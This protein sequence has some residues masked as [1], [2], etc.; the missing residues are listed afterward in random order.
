MSVSISDIYSEFHGVAPPRLGVAGS[1]DLDDINVLI[2]KNWDS[3][4]FSDFDDNPWIFVSLPRLAVPYYLGAY[5]VKSM[6][7]D[8]FM[9][10]SFRYLISAS[11]GGGRSRGRMGSLF[12][13]TVLNVKQLNLLDAYLH[14]SASRLDY[15]DRSLVLSFSNK[16]KG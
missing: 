12:L 10:E 2:G 14:Y 6:T 4:V 8:L 3:L 16:L 7:E 15:A 13:R 11:S 9:A 5:I 1:G